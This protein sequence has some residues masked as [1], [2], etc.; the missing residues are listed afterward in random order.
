[1]QKS[2]PAL[3]FTGSI[4]YHLFKKNEIIHADDGEMMVVRCALNTTITREEDWLCHNIFHT[5]CTS[6]GKVCDIIIDSGSCENVVSIKM[7]D[8]LKLPT[9]DHS[10]PYK[11]T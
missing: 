7:V 2:G 3:M 4:F 10:S 5:R 1:M 8:K 6:H 9:E 11:L